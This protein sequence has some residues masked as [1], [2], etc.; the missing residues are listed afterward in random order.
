MPVP[1]NPKGMRAPKKLT[2]KRCDLEAA[3]GHPTATTNT[4][5]TALATFK[6]ETQFK[7]IRSN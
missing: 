2:L 4:T 5:F 6:E 7:E 3:T 1:N